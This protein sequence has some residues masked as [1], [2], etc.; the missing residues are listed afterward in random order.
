MQINKF[1]DW[2]KVSAI[3]QA[4]SKNITPA[5]SIQLK[6]DGD[7][8]LEKIT[9]HID[10]QD[11]SWTPLSEVTIMLKNG[12]DTIYVDTGYLRANLKAIKVR[13]SRSGITFF[14][15]ASSQNIT[16]YGVNFGELM[17]WLE[18]GTDKIPPRPLMRPTYEEVKDILKKN[19]ANLMQE[20]VKGVSK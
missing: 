15:G 16:P 19:W 5:F 12:N 10:A 1:G 7:F 3:L 17:V 9:G 11:L 2:S 6:K 20:L 14:I 18:Y 4:L 8:I 13:S